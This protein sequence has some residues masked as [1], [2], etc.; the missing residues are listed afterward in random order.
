MIADLIL[1]LD[2]AS[3]AAKLDLSHLDVCF[4]NCIRNDNKCQF[5]Y[6]KISPACCPNRAYRCLPRYAILSHGASCIEHQSSRKLQLPGNLI[7]YLL[8]RNKSES[9]FT[10]T[11]QK[12]KRDFISSG[13]NAFEGDLKETWKI[14]NQLID[15]RFETT[16]ISSLEDRGVSPWLR[17]NAF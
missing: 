8:H 3:E 6:L 15:K 4:L 14:I 1:L 17:V 13:I 12:L 5:L 2:F 9:L 16:H 11:S 10:D 7:C